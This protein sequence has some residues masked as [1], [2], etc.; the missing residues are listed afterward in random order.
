MLLLGL[1]ALSCSRQ[2]NSPKREEPA[3]REILP[4]ARHGEKTMHPDTIKLVDWP[5]NEMVCTKEKL[6]INKVLGPYNTNFR[7]DSVCWVLV[8]AS[9]GIT[10]EPISG[11]W[12]NGI[13]TFFR[14][15]RNA[16]G[17]IVIKATPF[18]SGLISKPAEIK[19]LVQNCRDAGRVDRG[20]A[21]HENPE[22]KQCSANDTTIFNRQ[23]RKSI[24]EFSEMLYMYATTTSA[25][26]KEFFKTGAK[27]K[28]DEIPGKTIDI[29][30]DNEIGVVF[31]DPAWANPVVIPLY[32]N[33][34]CYIIGIRVRKK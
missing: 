33:Q 3:A 6:K 7:A 2:N 15:N 26:E 23:R 28:L 13:V 1:V 5:V 17:E 22:Y 31:D 18:K 27:H 29:L 32:D 25:R 21:V 19:F 16:T 30:P 9:P 34:R 8:S 10:M 4:A 12:D 20:R 11:K 14:Q 24:A